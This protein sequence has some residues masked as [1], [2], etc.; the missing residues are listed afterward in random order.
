MASP[1]VFTSRL[2]PSVA[3]FCAIDADPVVKAKKIR[4]LAAWYRALAAQAANPFIWEARLLTAEELD[5]EAN[6]IEAHAPVCR[7][8]AWR[9]RHQASADVRRSRSA[10]PEG[11]TRR[12]KPVTS[13]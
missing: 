1:I 4:D 7:T 6:R 2:S 5:G 9:Q 8:G 12:L 10:R 13:P 3:Q 11:Q